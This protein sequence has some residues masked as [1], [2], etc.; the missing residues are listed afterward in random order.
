MG[1]WGTGLYSG[2][3]ASDLRTTIGA[4]TRLPFDTDRLVEI[5]RETEPDIANDPDDPDYTV[6]WLVLAD[7]FYR[8]NLDSVRV[9]DAALAIID[10]SQDIAMQEKLGATPSDLG[11]RRK[12][13]AELRAK[14]VA[15]QVPS[16][17]RKTLNKPQPLLMEIGDL[18]VYPTCRGEAINPYFTEKELKDTVWRPDGW[19]ALLIIDCG[20]AFDFLAWYRPLTLVDSMAQKPN[21]D[22]LRSRMK[23]V[24]RSPG[25]CSAAHFKRMQFETMHR[26]TID[27]ARRG[28][29][30]PDL[31]PGVHEAVNDVS[32][33]NELGIGPSH[34]SFFGWQIQTAGEYAKVPFPSIGCLA[35]ITAR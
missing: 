34:S 15:P 24:L 5:L 4:V 7:Q 17:P 25:T 1:V 33:A 20:R 13:L 10:T 27:R 14:L 30:F 6:F 2:D 29:C 18:V 12:A 8:R 22:C 16:R 3:F 31:T 9:R 26:L 11:K 32:I 19:G 23:W 21:I 35:E 28:K